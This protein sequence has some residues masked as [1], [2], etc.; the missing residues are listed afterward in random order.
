MERAVKDLVKEMRELRLGV[1]E[2]LREL[3]LEVKRVR[4]SLEG[5]AAARREEEEEGEIVTEQQFDRQQQLAGNSIVAATAIQQRRTIIKGQLTRINNSLSDETTG[6]DAQVRQGKIEELWHKF[7]EIQKA[8]E[9]NRMNAIDPEGDQEDPEGA[10]TQEAEKE[11]EMFESTYYAAAAKIQRITLAAQARQEPQRLEA[12]IDRLKQ[13]DQNPSIKLPTLKLPEFKGEYDEWLLFKDAYISM[14]HTNTS[15]AAIQKFQYLRSALKGEAL[16]VI[17]GLEISAENYVNAWELLTKNYD[18]N[19]LL[20]NTHI[21]QLLDF[22]VV[23]RDKPAT[24]RQFVMHIR[25]HLKALKTLQLPVD[26]WDELLIHLT[27]GK[28]DYNTQK[29]WE[30]ETSRDKINR[31]TL[32]DYLTFLNERCRTLELL[33][34]GKGKRDTSKPATSKKHGNAVSLAATTQQRCSICTE[35]HMVYK[36]PQF[37]QLAVTERIREAKEKKLCLNCL[38]KGH[39]ATNC[40]ASACRKCE[41]KH[42]TLLHPVS[43]EKSSIAQSSNEDSEK[44]VIVHC[45]RNEAIKSP[46]EAIS[47]SS[48]VRK[49]TTQV[50]LSTA[51]IQVAD[52]ERKWQRCRVLLDPGSPSNLITAELVRKL[53]LKCKEECESISGINRSRM[54]AARKVTVKIRSMHSDYET[55]VDCLVLQ[56]ITEKI[57]QVKINVDAVSIPKGLLMADPRFHEPGTIDLLLGAGLF[58]Q[59]ICPDSIKQVKGLPRLQNTLLGWIVGGELVDTRDRNSSLFCGLITNS[60]LQSQLERFWIQEEIQET[61]SLTEEEADCERQFCESVRRDNGGRF[62][63]ALPVRPSVVLGDSTTQATRR[64]YS[65][66]RRF[67]ADPELK[68]AYVNFME[69]YENQGHMSLISEDFPENPVYTSTS[70]ADIAAMFRQIIVREEDRALQRILWR[71]SQTQQIRTYQLNTVTYGTAPAP[72]PAMRCL[73]QLADEEKV[74]HQAALVLM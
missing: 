36:C 73:Q 28:L 1:T 61:R 33:D 57:P 39:Y 44:K 49:S 74:F 52:A 34:K 13:E 3:R 41:K 20:I 7:E 31:K 58:W 72:Y 70:S 32:E 10:I 26:H 40:R 46:E 18:N 22:P 62:I 69:D 37:L 43:E 47:V 45:A 53:S 55:N 68:S 5:E 35:S 19:K 54:S 21:S 66:E 29:D 8:I 6:P 59:L 12:Q 50:I 17:G 64:L 4:E 15:I 2:E 30:E 14:I 42:N 25:T 38:G 67:K 51:E 24:I 27:K 23:A 60:A 9:E 16:Q 65:L 71:T 63:V 56:S 48:V 11:R